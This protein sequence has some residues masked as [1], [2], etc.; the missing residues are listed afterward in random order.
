MRQA[1]RSDGVRALRFTGPVQEPL[2]LGFFACRWQQV[3]DVVAAYLAEPVFRAAHW[4]CSV[5][6]LRS[7]AGY[8]AGRGPLGPGMV[9][10]GPSAGTPDSQAP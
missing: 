5:L 9:L 6:G 7:V 3:L 8:P 1:A 2:A 10:A 4:R